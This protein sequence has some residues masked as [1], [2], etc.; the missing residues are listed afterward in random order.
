MATTIVKGKD[1]IMSVNGVAILC[2]TS[3]SFSSEFEEIEA[4]CRES[5]DGY[6][7]E[8]GKNTASLELSGIM[9]YDVP[10]D[11]GQMR[12][13]D[14]LS[15]HKNKTR[16]DFIFGTK[17]LGGDKEIFGQA[18][19]PSYSLEGDQDGLGT[20][21]ITFKVVGDWDFRDVAAA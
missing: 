20:Y 5:G 12:A 8:L 6:D 10:V 9:K 17:D 3:V 11:A 1:I 19:L 21:S 2:A 18:I 4:A 16:V 14:L 13:Y 7:A 15:L